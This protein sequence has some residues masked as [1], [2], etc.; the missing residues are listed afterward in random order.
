MVRPRFAVL[1]ADGGSQ[2]SQRQLT[3]A[4]LPCSSRWQT[5]L[6]LHKSFL[7]IRSISKQGPNEVHVTY[8]LP[9][10]APDG[11]TL[12]LVIQPSATGRQK[13]TLINATVRPS[14][15]GP[16][17]AVAPVR[18]CTPTDARVRLPPPP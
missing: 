4:S 5:T 17:P 14:L 16:L 18:V 10:D 7:S 1:P 11:Q 15:S 8:D 9:Q 12:V 2:T 13:G 6:A 3:S